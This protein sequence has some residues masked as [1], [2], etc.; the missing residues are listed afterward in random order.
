MP[1]TASTMPASAGPT[2]TARLSTALATALAA[3]SSWGVLA[4]PGV[5][6]A[7]AERNGVV[8]IATAIESPYT[9]HGSDSAYT[10]TAATPMSTTRVTFVTSRTRSRG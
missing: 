6:A 2:N 10:A 4:R 1:D 8:A 5:R 9:I 3:V 7:C